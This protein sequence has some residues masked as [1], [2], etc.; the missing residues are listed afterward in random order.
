MSQNVSQNPGL[1]RNSLVVPLFPSEHQLLPLKKS[2][3]STTP[4]RSYLRVFYSGTQPTSRQKRHSLGLF[5]CQRAN[6]KLLAHSLRSRLPKG[7]QLAN[8]LLD[9]DTSR[10][11]RVTAQSTPGHSIIQLQSNSIIT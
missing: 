3:G 2:E 6:C 4:P 7:P 5:N 8:E 10:L 11:R 1:S 9:A